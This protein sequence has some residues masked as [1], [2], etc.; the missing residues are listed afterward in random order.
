[1]CIPCV[2]GI[3]TK[4]LFPEINNLNEII[5]DANNS[6]IYFKPR[7][8]IKKEKNI[9]LTKIKFTKS[10]VYIEDKREIISLISKLYYKNLN[11]KLKEVLKFIRDNYREYL[12]ISNKDKLKLSQSYFYNLADFL[13]NKFVVI[14]KKNNYSY[15][16]LLNTFSKIYQGKVPVT[17]LEKTYKVIRGYIQKMDENATIDKK[18][19]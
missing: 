19:L 11:L 14:L 18:Q 6:K 17:K 5:V 2:G 12:K 4:Q 1:L 10:K 13:Q 7:I 8:D 16:Y 9:S 15:D 3:D